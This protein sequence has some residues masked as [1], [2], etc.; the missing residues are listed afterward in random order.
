[1]E[2]AADDLAAVVYTSGTTGKPKPV[3]LSH[4]NLQASVAS[5]PRGATPEDD[6]SLLA[7]PLAHLFGVRSL[8]G[9]YL[10]GGRSVLMRR[11]TAPEALR[12]IER[13]RACEMA[14]VPSMFLHMLRVEEPY[15]ISTMKRWRVSAGP[16]PESACAAFTARFGGVMLASYGLMEASGAVSAERRSK[17]KAGSSGRALLGVRLAIVDDSGQALAPDEVGEIYTAGEHVAR[18][19][20]GHT[21]AS[22][23]VFAD[24]WLRTGDVGYVDGEGYLFVLERKRDLIVSGGEVVYPREVEEVLLQLPLVHECAVVAVPDPALGDSIC[25][26]VVAD[27]ALGGGALIAHCQTLLPAHKVPRHVEFVSALPRTAIGSVKRRALRAWA[28]KQLASK[29]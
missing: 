1:A 21:Q 6:V 18:G 26:C 24:G 29:S 15:H 13:H 10:F 16:L 11:F 27:A 20:Y 8:V 3:M 14:G 7:L 4:Q 23:A 25:A 28:T 19:Y 17:R 22:A 5:E 2:R 9:N 12:L